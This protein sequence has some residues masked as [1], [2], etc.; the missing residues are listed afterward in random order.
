MHG[1]KLKGRLLMQYAPAGDQGRVWMIHKPESQEPY[2]ATHKLEE[3]IEELRD[4]GQEKLVWSKMPGQEPK[5]INIQRCPFKK[6]RYA[7]ILKADEE[8]RLVFGVIS[9][10]DTVDLQGDV[11]SREEIARMARNFVDYVREFRDRHTL[12]KVK[13]EIVR[14]WIAD[15]DEWMYGQLVKAGSW[16]L[17]VRVLDDEIWGKV[18]AGI[19]RAFSIGGRGVR[20]ERAR[21][22][23]KRSVTGN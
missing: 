8:K 17:L 11:L 1:E 2:T 18:K 23:H 6:Q 16:L 4:K 5:I 7:A 13:V 10:P 9:E 14:S 15:K 21:P 3:V 19:Y 22:D 12:K 20:I